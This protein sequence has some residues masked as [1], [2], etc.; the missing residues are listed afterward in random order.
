MNFGFM[1]IKEKN[2][3]I[4]DFKIFKDLSIANCP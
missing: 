3:M 4:Y 1:I 2:V